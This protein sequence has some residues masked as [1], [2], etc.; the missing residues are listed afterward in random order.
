MTKRPVRAFTLVELVLTLAII[1]M[2]GAM[3]LPVLSET[4]YSQT[5]L[6]CRMRLKS[7]HAVLQAYLEASDGKY[8][9]PINSYYGNQF[10]GLVPH[11]VAELDVRLALPQLE[12]LKKVGATRNMFYCPF[13]DESCGEDQSW[14]FLSGTW[15]E[16]YCDDSSGGKVAVIVYTGYTFFFCRDY[17]YSRERFANG[18]VVVWDR[19]GEDS[20]PIVGDTLHCRMSGGYSSGWY[21][22]GG[23][24]D[25]LFNSDCNTLLKGG[26]V[27]HT[28]QEE[29]DWPKPALT[30]GYIDLWWC[31]LV[32]AE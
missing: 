28:N 20:V 16:P 30:M 21:H 23:L 3:V 10:T 15:D 18:Q 19:N 29:F 2:L 13:G 22:G 7:L 17:P 6:D 1:A 25:G 32:D 5:D 26:A 14:R 27:V 11:E 12:L 4:R 9:Y 8:P 24:P 31:H